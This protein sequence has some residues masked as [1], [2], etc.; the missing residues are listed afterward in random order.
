M[1][2]WPCP[3]VECRVQML[4]K[5]MAL[6]NAYVGRR[7]TTDFCGGGVGAVR[8]PPG[9]SR[10]RCSAL[11]FP[12]VTQYARA[13]LLHKEQVLP[14]GMETERECWKRTNGARVC[15]SLIMRYI[16]LFIHVRCDLF[17]GFQIALYSSHRLVRLVGSL[18][19]LPWSHN[20]FI[21]LPF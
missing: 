12:P 9:S 2:A 11:L 8:T 6:R 1:A 21:P 3:A 19:I 7:P 18:T 17:I 10:S 14:S 4:L 20:P 16:D 15:C 5:G 13:R